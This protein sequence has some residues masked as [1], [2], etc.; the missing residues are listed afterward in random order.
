MTRYCGPILLL[1]AVALLLGCEELA[2]LLQNK[3]PV[4]DRLIAIRDRLLP[5]DTTTVLIE[6]H[7]PEGGALSYEWSAEQGTLSTTTGR[8]AV[9]TAP[10]A[11][12]Y[13]ISVK[14]FDEKRSETQGQVTLTVLGSE[15][16][17]VKIMQPANGAF[18]PG[19]GV[20]TIEAQASHPNGIQRVEFLVG[21]K[22]LG[23]ANSPTPQLLYRQFWQLEGLSGPATIIARAF[24]AR[25]SGAPGVDSVRVS[26]EGVTRLE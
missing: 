14:V 20:I 11:G 22:I 13:K 23:S 8:H 25:D 18:I 3:P 24:R 9:W 10:A 12:N 4:I 26:I 16:P 6:A 5:T 1:F 17:V 21:D 19:L 7:D 15:N 2:S